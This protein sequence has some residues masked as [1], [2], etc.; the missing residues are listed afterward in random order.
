MSFAMRLH[1]L[2]LALVVVVL[3][4]WLFIREAFFTVPDTMQ[5]MFIVTTAVAS[6][7]VAV[8][9]F[10]VVRAAAV[11][12]LGAGLN[13]LVILANG[14]AMPVAFDDA[15]PVLSYEITDEDVG[16]LLPRTKDVLL[17]SEDIHLPWLAD[18][19]RLWFPT[20]G[21]TLYSFGDLVLY[22]GIVLAGA[23]AVVHV[24]RARIGGPREPADL[25]IDA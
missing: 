6:T 10:R 15:R 22:A 25:P 1:Y 4:Q 17:R 11:V 5:R 18:R 13:L 14:G 21:S 24:S 9:F 19:F 16:H 7:A 2:L 8:L 20:G 12:A 3:A 23:E